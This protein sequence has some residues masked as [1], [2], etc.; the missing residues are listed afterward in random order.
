MEI[1][2]KQHEIE[3]ALQ[4]FISS[5]G[6]DLSD[7]IV[8]ISFVSG[9]KDNGLSAEISIEDTKPYVPEYVKRKPVEVAEAIK[10]VVAT[11]VEAI[12]E[13]PVKPVPQPTTPYPQAELPGNG[14]DEPVVPVVLAASNLF[15]IAE[16][17]TDAQPVDVLSDTAVSEPVEEPVVVKTAMP[18]KGISLFN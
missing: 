14:P 18:L 16:L 1:H 10:E 2:L 11:L 15:S 8:K 4:G 12:K 9:R 3:N 7:K 17:T 6:I 5:Q 13:E